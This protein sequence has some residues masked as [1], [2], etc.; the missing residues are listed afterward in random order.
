MINCTEVVK[1]HLANR[2]VSEGR[3][4]IHLDF[5]PQTV[6]FWFSWGDSVV[7]KAQSGSIRFSGFLFQGTMDF[8]CVRRRFQR[9]QPR[10]AAAPRTRQVSAPSLGR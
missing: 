2:G 3:V 9:A 4:S 6:T 7:T 8:S 10:E 5:L 1:C